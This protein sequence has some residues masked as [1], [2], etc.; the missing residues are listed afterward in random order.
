MC[1]AK[2]CWSRCGP[3]CHHCLCSSLSCMVVCWVVRLDDIFS[4]ESSSSSDWHQASAFAF[5]SWDMGGGHRC[6]Q[7]RA[8]TGAGSLLGVGLAICS[9]SAAVCPLQR[10]SAHSHFHILGWPCVHS[11]TS[12]Q[13]FEQ[14]IE[15][16]NV[17]VES[18]SGLEEV[19]CGF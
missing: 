18:E 17:T 2:Q 8:V 4:W 10:A 15:R 12:W 19:E 13:G 9:F 3:A 6:L 11:K 5:M 7:S 1:I 14:C 16:E